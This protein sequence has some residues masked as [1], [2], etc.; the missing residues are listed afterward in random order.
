M[1]RAISSP[2]PLSLPM[3]QARRDGSSGS[4]LDGVL[5]A[6]RPARALCP[7]ARFGTPMCA[8][9]H[10]TLLGIEKAHLVLG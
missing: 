5:Y 7:R 2:R 10:G 3:R 4:R 6:G 9:E 8:A 1:V